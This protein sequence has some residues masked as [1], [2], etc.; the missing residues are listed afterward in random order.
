M[1]GP[2][3][4]WVTFPRKVFPGNALE[5]LLY[6]GFD[7]VYDDPS[8]KNLKGIYD[9]QNWANDLDDLS[10]SDLLFH[11]SLRYAENHDEVRLAGANQWGGI[12]MEVGRA[13]SA[14][15]FGVG[16]GPV[17]LFNGQEVGEPARGAAGRV[18]HDGVR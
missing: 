1:I 13:A 16:R 10:R 14:I 18:D 11:R 15:L 3:R 5:G 6:A 8:Y 17:L 2:R 12:G 7:A 4:I 9:G